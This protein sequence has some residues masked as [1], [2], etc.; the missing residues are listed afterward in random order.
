MMA[1]LPSYLVV[2]LQ[3]HSMLVRT[4]I[5]PGLVP[6]LLTNLEGIWSMPKVGW[7]MIQ[8]RP[9]SSWK[10]HTLAGLPREVDL[11]LS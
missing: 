10:W 4:M 11:G 5:F 9:A 3:L 2:I 1:L 7:K 8:I 6:K